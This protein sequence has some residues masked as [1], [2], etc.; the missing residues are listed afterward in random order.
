MGVLRTALSVRSRP[1]TALGH[2][3]SLEATIASVA[4]E[5]ETLGSPRAMLSDMAL[6]RVSV[7]FT[8]RDAR[9]AATLRRSVLVAGIVVG[10]EATGGCGGTPGASGEL[11][12][13][14]DDDGTFEMVAES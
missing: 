14:G 13:D 11:G 5:T 6:A 1:D 4:V 3:N 2:G 10:R 12:G 7:E 8:S 9:S